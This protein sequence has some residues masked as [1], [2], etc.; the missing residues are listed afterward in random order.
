ML[1]ADV[2]Q[3]VI[4]PIVHYQEQATVTQVFLG[5][6]VIHNDVMDAVALARLPVTTV[7]QDIGYVD[8][9]P[10]VADSVV[11]N[12]DVRSF[13]YGA[14]VALLGFFVVGVA[15]CD[16]DRLPVLREPAPRV[17]KNVGF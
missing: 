12:G 10:G 7:H 4:G 8:P 11:A 5:I 6:D 14:L 3:S 17:L 9:T 15:G 1:D 2:V 16:Q 13:T